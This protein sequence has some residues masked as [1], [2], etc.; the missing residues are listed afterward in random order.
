MPP[1][2]VRQEEVGNLLLAALPPEEFRQLA[3][4]LTRVGLEAGERLYEPEEAVP[5]V[6]FTEGGLLCL[7]STLEDGA[8]VEVGA[9][10]REGLGGLLVLFGAE[11]AAH[12][13][14][15]RVGATALRV[16]T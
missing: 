10:G 8:S 6:H 11:V 1:L 5:F 7:L 14:A 12:T 4:H 9:L 16:R 15:V 3:P 2:A 13:A